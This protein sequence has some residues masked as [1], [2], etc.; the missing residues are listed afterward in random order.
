ATSTA[1][2]LRIVFLMRAAS[3]I[4]IGSNWG[5]KISTKIHIVILLSVPE[6]VL[7]GDHSAASSLS[8]GH[9]DSDRE[10]TRR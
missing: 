9:G 10:W 1:V 7:V 4:A 3:S 2:Q 6:F 8:I 5:L